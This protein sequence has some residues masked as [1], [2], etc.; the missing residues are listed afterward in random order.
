MSRVFELAAE[1]RNRAGKGAART[2]RR[3]GRLPGVVYG[4]KR[5]PQMI[6]MDPGPLLKAVNTG[7]F[8]ATIV[9]L[10]VNG[11]TERVIARDVQFDPVSDQPVHVDFMRLGKGARVDVAVGVQFNNEEASPGIKRGGVLNIVR[12]EVSLNCPADAIPE[13]IEIDLTGLQINDSV[14]ISAV[15]LPQGVTPT[16]TDRDF[17]IA[18][19]AAPSGLSISDD[20]EEGDEEGEEAAEDKDTEQEK[21]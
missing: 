11:K 8:L 13:V 9:N 10:Q 21:E 16:I 1:E 5:N 15:T 12:H 19:I 18:T 14:H 20:E 17:T 3:E 7:R 6:T 2:I 4:D